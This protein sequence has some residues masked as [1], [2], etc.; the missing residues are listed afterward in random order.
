MGRWERWKGN[1]A[2]W[3]RRE[4]GEVGRCEVP[5]FIHVWGIKGPEDFQLKSLNQ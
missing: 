2:R 1:V 5:G 4:S 3:E